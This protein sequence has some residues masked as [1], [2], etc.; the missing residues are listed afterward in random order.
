MFETIPEKLGSLS[1]PVRVEL[2]YESVRETLQIAYFLFQVRD[3]INTSIPNQ[4]SDLNENVCISQFFAFT[5]SPL[6]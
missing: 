3:M 4:W 6:G 1:K 5:P 2:I